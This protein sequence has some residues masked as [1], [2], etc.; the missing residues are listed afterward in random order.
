MAISTEP[1]TTTVAIP[2]QRKGALRVFFS[3]LFREKKLGAAGAV[4]V[5]LFFIVG[6][7]ADFLAP[8]GMKERKLRDRLEG[9]SL[10]YPLGTDHLGRDQLSRVIYGAQISMIVGVAASALQV[11]IATIFGL[12]SGYFSGK[13]DLLLQ[14]L[15]DAW[16]SFP[17]LFVILTVMSLLGPGWCKSS[18]CWARFGGSAISA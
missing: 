18:L 7:F 11:V 2:A 13:F 8:R 14:R 12:L 4:I 10:K 17:A 3:R 9:P 15:V 1:P 5:L 6:V 16:L